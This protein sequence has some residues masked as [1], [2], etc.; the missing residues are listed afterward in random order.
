MKKFEVGKK[1][2]TRSVCDYDC[3]FEYTI[4]ARTNSTVTAVDKFGKV[5]K[6]RISKK[7]SEFRDAETF[8]PMGNY[9]MCPMISA[10]NK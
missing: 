3:I 9:S 5:A 8:L 10:N 1:Y 2:T 4:T 6:Y 7:Y